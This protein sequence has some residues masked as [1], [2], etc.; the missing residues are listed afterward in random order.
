MR[1]IAFDV[2]TANADLS[3]ICQIGLAYFEDGQCVE[4]WETL[5]NP[6]D[7]FVPINV[8]K[9]GITQD[10]VKDA[11]RF[12]D[13]AQEFRRRL[14]DSV[15]VT[16]TKFDLAA[17]RSVFSKH[18]LKSPEFKWIDT[19]RVVRHVWDE[20][21]IRG[22]GLA[23]VTAKLGI[24]FKH[25]CAVEDA[26]AA[27]EILVHAIRHSG[28]A[29]DHW[30]CDSFCEPNYTKRPGKRTY[31]AR[32][33]VKR[34]GNPVGA[35]FGEVLVFTG[36]LS[37]SRNEAADV[38]AAAG[39]CVEASVTKRTTILVV[40]DQ[41]VRLLA[42][43]DKSSK[44]I[45]AEQLITNGQPIRILR[46]SDFDDVMIDAIGSDDNPPDIVERS[47]LQPIRPPMS[48]A[49]RF[50]GTDAGLIAAWEAGRGLREKNS[51][52]A[53]QA[54]NGELPVLCWAGGLDD[55]LADRKFGSLNYLAMWQGLRGE[56]LKIDRSRMTR[57][58]CCKWNTTVA[59]T[60]DYAFRSKKLAEK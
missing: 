40:G 25:H 23:S 54:M 31:D 41:D 51:E 9:H 36:Q 58:T 29:L 6:E 19:A 47:F 35:M 56:D 50:E 13:V 16:H 3:S 18:R 57:I 28:L 17:V 20:F 60:E 15:I 49:E 46:E 45:R 37:V 42:G 1:F 10:T 8:G 5:I 52:L 21:S 43:K 44:H 12:T 39:C 4:K 24:K 22:Y 11:P 27:G 59:F 7:V 55:E 32:E 2:E 53:T 34:D 38:A 33:S 26:K 14:T 30:I 48:I